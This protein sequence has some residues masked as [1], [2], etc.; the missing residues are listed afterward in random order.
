MRLDNFSPQKVIRRIH[1]YF[2]HTQDYRN[3]NYA[4]TILR[5]KMYKPWIL[6]FCP[7]KNKDNKNF[8]D[9]KSLAGDQKF[10]LSR[11]LAPMS[12]S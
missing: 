1:K 12:K 9:H 7:K 2:T 4:G 6:M 10:L 11:R 5:V 8:G 3:V